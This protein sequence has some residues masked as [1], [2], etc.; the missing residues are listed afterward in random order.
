MNTAKIDNV[1]DVLRLDLDR[2]ADDTN[3][4]PAKIQDIWETVSNLPKLA[5]ESYLK[6]LEHKLNSRHEWVAGSYNNPKIRTIDPLY[7]VEQEYPE[8]IGIV[9]ILREQIEGEYTDSIDDLQGNINSLEAELEVAYEDKDKLEDRVKDLEQECKD[10]LYEI[11]TLKDKLND[12]AAAS[13]AY[14]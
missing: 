6:E 14:G 10:Y 3:G 7:R 13:I 1:L 4:D 12:F 11:D 9:E 2:V 8:L 5:I